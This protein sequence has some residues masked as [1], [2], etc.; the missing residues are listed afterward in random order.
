LPNVVA[1]LGLFRDL[2][3]EVAVLAGNHDLWARAGYSS[4][5]LWERDLPAAVHDTGMLWLED[6]VWKR[7]GV[8]VAG[9][10]AWYDYSA[11]DSTWAA[12][13]DTSFAANKGRYNMDARFLNWPWSDVDFAA[14]LGDG[15]RARLEALERDPAI[16]ATVAVTHVPLFE[17][18]MLRQAH[19]PRWGYS[20]A[21]FGNL[22]LGGRII[23]M[24]KLCA[25]VSGHTHVGRQGVARRPEAP[26]QPP[27]PVYVLPSDYHRPAFMVVEDDR[28]GR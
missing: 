13:S 21:Y 3:G 8:A 16:H 20:N 12:E 19:D 6:T 25:V 23:G 17:E 22:T 14:R 10:L 28:K 9:S 7:D 1:C 26:E 27:V 11:A 18:Q 4:Q 2:P 5:A 24:A 15:F